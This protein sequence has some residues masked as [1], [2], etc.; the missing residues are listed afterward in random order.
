MEHISVHVAQL[1]SDALHQFVI[2]ESP[3]HLVDPDKSNKALGFPALITGLYQFYRVPTTPA[4]HIRPP[5]N[6]SFMD[7]YCMPS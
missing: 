2:T 7:K 6:R 3:R 4:K 1:I 5:I